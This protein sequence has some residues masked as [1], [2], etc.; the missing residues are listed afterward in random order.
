MKALII[1]D[2]AGIRRFLR[3]GLK[4][5][6]FDVV[7]AANGNEGL[8]LVTARRPDVIVLDLGLPDADGQDLVPAI[9]GVSQ[10][11]LIVLSVRDAQDQKVTALDAGADD[12]LTKPFDFG[13]LAARIR[14]FRRKAWDS[15]EQGQLVAGDLTLDLA[16]REVRLDNASISLTPKE[17]ELL[18]LLMRHRDKLIEHREFLEQIWGDTHTHDNTYLRV[19]IQ[20]LRNKLT[21]AGDNTNRIV[22]Q[23]GVGYRLVSRP[24]D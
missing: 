23:P 2:D 11:I 15:D 9:R 10:A 4:T 21:N 24:S 13:E 17:F 12:Y 22:S 3:I 20:R 18:S 6:G 14:A 19:Y 1:D 8:R 7:E 5:E 16:T